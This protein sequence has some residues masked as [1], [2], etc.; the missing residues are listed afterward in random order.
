MIPA[1]N[2]AGTIA[3]VVD[4]HLEVLKTLDVPSEI[5]ILDDGS[6]DETT[7][8]LARLAARTPFLRT[9]RHATNEGIGKSL[10]ELYERASGQW[11][12][13]NA[14]DGQIPARELQKLWAAREGQ[15]LVI[16]W[17]RPRRDPAGRLAAAW[18]YSLLLRQL[19]GVRF[20][21][22]HSVKLYSTEAL[23]AAWPRSTSSFAEDEILVR[24]TRAGRRV[25]EIPIE[26]KPR[27]S[28]R[29]HGASLAIASRATLDLLWF[30]SDPKKGA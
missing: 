7:V 23:R 30:V 26:H 16:G 15:A 22:V 20:H 5:L 4:E 27:T 13:F 9:Y 8:T 12:F 3:Q 6:T 25:V 24:L 18:L 29:A 10:L 19:L 17:R 28:G 14:A 2:E 21:D 11:I 1:H